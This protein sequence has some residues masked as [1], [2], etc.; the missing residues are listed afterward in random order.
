MTPH[1]IECPQCG[2]EGEWEHP[3]LSTPPGITAECPPD[4]VMVDCEDCD[5]KGWRPMTDDELA[6]AAAD[7]FSDMCEGEPPVTMDEQH[8]AAFQ[9]KM[10]LRR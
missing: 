4:P 6:E 8:S 1:E 2:G 7:A 9:Q 10:E 5:G 3:H